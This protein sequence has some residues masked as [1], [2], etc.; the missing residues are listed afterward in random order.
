MMSRLWSP[1]LPK[2][3]HIAYSFILK[4]SNRCLFLYGQFIWFCLKG[5][6]GDDDYLFRELK[7]Q[8][9]RQS[10]RTN[11]KWICTRT[12]CLSW[13]STSTCPILFPIPSLTPPLLY[14]PAPKLPLLT[15]TT[16][17][18]AEEITAIK[19]TVSAWSA[20][21][22]LPSTATT[23][24]HLSLWEWIGVLLLANGYLSLFGFW[25]NFSLWLCGYTVV[26]FH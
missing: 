23:A 13:T 25:F 16:A 8:P 2:L 12:T 21:V 20:V 1:A 18:T 19:A 6:T 15:T 22:A 3:S 7:D 24:L 26:K 5:Q 14:F 17:A 11:R 10:C 4:S 9:T